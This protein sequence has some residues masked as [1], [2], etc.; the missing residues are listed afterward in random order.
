MLKPNFSDINECT[1]GTDTCQQLCL[2]TMGSYSCDCD[3]GYRLASDGFICNDI[4]ECGENP[5]GCAQNCTNTEGSYTCSC[6][7]GYSLAS[8]DHWCM[9]KINI[10]FTDSEIVTYR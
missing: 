10:A 8:D 2:N 4:D 7:L 9:G 3:P 6:R 1:E 5:D